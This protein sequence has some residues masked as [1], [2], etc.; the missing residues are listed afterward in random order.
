MQNE[1][2]LNAAER[3]LESAL[4]SLAPRSAKIDPVAAAFEAGRRSARRQVRLW[5]SAAAAMLLVSAGAWLVPVSRDGVAVAPR[6]VMPFAGSTARATQPFSVQSVARLRA[7]VR[8]RG[9]DGLPVVQIPAAELMRV[10][11][12]L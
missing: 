11:N 9:L 8:E 12:R 1:D 2:G 5:Q 10:D 6:R 7:A 3:E 4:R